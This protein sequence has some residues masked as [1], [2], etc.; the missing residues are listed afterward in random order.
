MVE[1]QLRV[2]KAAFLSSFWLSDGSADF[3]WRF[4][5][6]DS[7]KGTMF[8]V[9]WTLVSLVGLGW[10]L[11]LL[12]CTLPDNNTTCIK[13]A[14]SSKAIHNRYHSSSRLWTLALLLFP[15]YSS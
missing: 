13:P 3:A 2:P 11:L 14:S 7:L 4:G 5:A 6:D 1:D 12:A 8:F 15:S 9:Y 10:F